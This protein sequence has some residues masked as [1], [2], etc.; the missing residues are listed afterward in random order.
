MKKQSKAR[1]ID[2]LPDYT[3]LEKSLTRQSA[4]R[5]KTTIVKA[6]TVNQRRVLIG[7]PTTGLIRMEWHFNQ[8][9]LV[10]PVNWSSGLC[11]PRLSR[12]MWVSPMGFA[13]DHARNICA[14]Q[15]LKQGFEW[16][17]FIDHDTLIPPDT[18]IRMNYYMDNKI[19]PIVSGLY[20]NKALPS[21]PLIF[22]G[23]GNHYY[24]D[25][26]WGDAVWVDAVVM[27]CTLI[28]R[29][30]LEGL[31][32]VSEA[33]TDNEYALLGM[34]ADIV[35]HKMFVT[36]R[37]VGI[38]PET[39]TVHKKM[40]TEDLHFCDRVRSE[41]ILKNSKTWKH[42]ADKEYPFITDTAIFCTHIDNE[43][44][45][46]PIETWKIKQRKG[47]KMLLTSRVG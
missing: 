30:I 24:K 23:I 25:W 13:V 2:A 41:G 7:I 1:D 40:G 4:E 27:G 16:L 43:G 32:N 39:N 38:D 31:A 11:S 5:N 37:E 20:G 6:T 17:L 9:N 34:V 28:H 3:A 36:P 26:K 12:N 14:A 15:A 29:E 10:I 21:D 47:K 33:Y 42:L 22:R 18:F 46:Y 8:S 45:Q 35:I 19:S 44:R